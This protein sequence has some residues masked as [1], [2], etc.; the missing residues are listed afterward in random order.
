[1]K[2]KDIPEYVLN[3]SYKMTHIMVAEV[4]NGLFQYRRCFTT[5]SGATRRFNTVI[6]QYPN[7]H[8]EIVAIK[9]ILKS[10]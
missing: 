1:M 4:E 3:P 7:T 10:L 9:D 8:F 6:K 2:I 5:K